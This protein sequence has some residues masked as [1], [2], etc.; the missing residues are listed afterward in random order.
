MVWT[1]EAIRDFKR[2]HNL[3][4][5]AMAEILG[6]NRSYIFLLMNGQKTPSEIIQR[7]LDCLDSK[8]N[9]K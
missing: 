9:V 8:T 4:A 6:V 2:R 3:T 7:L 5:P 1:P